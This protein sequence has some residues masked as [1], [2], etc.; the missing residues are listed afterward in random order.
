MFKASL[1]FIT[2]PY[3]RKEKRDREKGRRRKDG[4]KEGR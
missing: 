1:G 3:Q 4:R 2:S